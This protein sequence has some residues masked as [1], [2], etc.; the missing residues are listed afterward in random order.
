[1][2]DYNEYVKYVGLVDTYST[3]D[4]NELKAKI[5]EQATKLIEEYANQEKL[6]EFEKELAIYYN[7]TVMADL[8]MDKASEENP[9]DITSLLVNPSFTENKKGWTGNFTTDTNLQNAEAYNTNFRIEQ[10]L[11]SL[12]AGLYTVKVKSFY[13]DGDFNAAY[14]HVWFDDNFTPNVKLFANNKETNVVSLCN[15]DAIFTERSH[16]QYTFDAVNP[17]AELG[18]GNQT[19][20]AW[21]E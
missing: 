1:M 6:V 3:V 18:E 5:Q 2:N 15:E 21:L 16:T 12:P 14:E 9:V 13:R 20:N 8:G 11:Y 10:T 7:Q 19:L 4:N 17:A